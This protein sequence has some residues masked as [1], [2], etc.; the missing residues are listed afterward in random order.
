MCV[1][2]NYFRCAFL[3]IVIEVN[4]RLISAMLVKADCVRRVFT[5]KK[6]HRTPQT[7]LL[8]LIIYHVL[9]SCPYQVL[10]L[11]IYYVLF[12]SNRNLGPFQFG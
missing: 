7:Q 8:T 4:Q 12:F 11:V 6:N 3:A 2:V 5:W 9:L 10:T 1:Y